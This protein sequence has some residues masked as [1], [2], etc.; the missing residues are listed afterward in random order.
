MFYFALS[1]NNLANFAFKSSI[2]RTALNLNKSI[3]LGSKSRKE[4]L[5]VN[6]PKT[7]N[8]NIVVQEFENEVLIYDLTINKAFCLNQTSKMIWQMCNG[9]NSV[10]DIA[11]NLKQS[12]KQQDAALRIADHR[13]GPDRRC[14]RGGRCSHARGR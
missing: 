4:I 1:A 11:D 3:F 13:A 12:L 14:L 8:E 7:R 2:F 5:T 9:K 6:K 10:A